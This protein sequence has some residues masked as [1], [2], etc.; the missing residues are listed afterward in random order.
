MARIDFII[1]DAGAFALEVNTVPGL[2]YE[3]NFIS[4]ASLAGFGYGDV[5]LALMHEALGRQQDDIPLPVLITGDLHAQ[6]H[7]GQPGREGG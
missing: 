4:A 3:S 6:V 7:D 2:S 5:L 1:T